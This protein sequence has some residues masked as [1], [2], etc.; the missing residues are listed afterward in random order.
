MGTAPS[1]RAVSEVNRINLFYPLMPS[2]GTRW[3]QSRPWEG[4]CVGINAHL[5]TLTAALLRELSL[6]GGKWVVSAADEATT[7]GN[8][9]WTRETLTKR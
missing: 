9:G 7:D 6:G 5:T 1:T 3:A 4:M 2:L 8:P